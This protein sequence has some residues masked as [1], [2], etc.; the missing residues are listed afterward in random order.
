[1]EVAASRMRLGLQ[2]HTVSF[3][4]SAEMHMKIISFQISNIHPRQPGVK[5]VDAAYSS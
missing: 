1:M 5:L 3:F 2:D 4:S